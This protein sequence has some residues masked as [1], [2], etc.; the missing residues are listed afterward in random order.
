MIKMKQHSLKMIADISNANGAP[1]FEDDVT[2]EVKKYADGLGE[3][4]E[5][6]LR[7]VY[8]YRRE[9]SGAKPV[10]QLDAHM[11]EV[12]FMVQAIRPD[13]NLR[14][15]PLGG[16]VLSNVPAHKV[17][18]RN[19]DGE[20]IAGL[21]ASKPPHYMSESEKRQP[22]EWHH[23]T[24]DVGAVSKQDAEENFKIRIGEP[25]VPDVEFTYD[26][27]HDLMVGKSFD[28]RLGCAT[29]IDTLKALEGTKL[30]VD[31]VG[32]CCSQEEIGTRGS[33]V[34]ARSV[35]PD[36][37]IVFEGCPADDTCVE[38]YM[39]QTALKKGPMLRHIDARMITSPRWQRYALDTAHKLG[40]PVQEAVRS[41]G[42][43]NGAN[44]H[45]ANEGVPTIVIGIPVRYAHTH[46]GISSFYD[47][48]NAVKLAVEL[49]KKLDADIIESF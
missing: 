48:E 47:Y 4:K 43:T 16:W 18:V 36:I 9:N 17:W 25:V 39:V 41:G 38:S 45:L 6:K 33:V 2:V 15:I 21:T 24:V 22:L 28:C 40:I 3:I 49:L 19:A 30:N 12:A 44:I 26:E 46:Y 14:V 32:A 31:I 8:I 11:D 34:T 37:A 1:G 10:V 20:Y 35:N 27:K 5:D 42:S 7:N 29:M 13:G 23:I